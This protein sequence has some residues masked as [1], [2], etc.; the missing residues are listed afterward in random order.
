MLNYVEPVFRPPSEGR[1]LILQVTN[2][3]SWNKCTFCDM[4]TQPQKKFKAKPED[5]T[6][7]EIKKAAAAGPQFEKVFLADGDALVLPI[8][9]LVEILSLIHI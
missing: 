6:L 4:Y 3:C 2:G 5:E 1:S 9:R 7:A 8:R